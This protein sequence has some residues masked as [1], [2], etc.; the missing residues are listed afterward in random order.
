MRR[1]CGDM[2]RLS[3]YEVDRRKLT[4]HGFVWL[5]ILQDVAL[6]SFT[7]ALDY[8]KPIARSVLSKRGSD[9][10]DRAL[11]SEADEDSTGSRDDE[12]GQRRGADRGFRKGLP[13]LVSGW[14]WPALVFVLFLVFFLV[15]SFV[16]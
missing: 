7:L 16:C 15:C 11:D 10:G 3:S 13:M 5:P 6:S 4:A 8:V 1:R 9:G 14:R 12:N 2:D